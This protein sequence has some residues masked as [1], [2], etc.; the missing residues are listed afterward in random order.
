[1]SNSSPN[2]NRPPMLTIKL[3]ENPVLRAQVA[4]FKAREYIRKQKE[5]RNGR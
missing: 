4:A 3:E 2:L 1:M 5:R